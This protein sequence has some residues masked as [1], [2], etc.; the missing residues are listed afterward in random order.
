MSDITTIISATELATVYTV[1]NV[2]SIVAAV[3]LIVAYWKIFEKA[4]EPGWKSIVP[5]YNTY[6]MY[7]LLFSSG[8]M[9]L[10][11]FIPVVNIVMWVMRCKRTSHAFGHGA[12]YTLGLM[13]LPN[14]FAMI[15][16]FNS[17]EF[18]S[19]NAK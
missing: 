16:G 3:F 7:K 14:I 9:F 19:E 11:E 4:G 17:D 2:I 15:L 8:W 1:A 13:F 6:T 10:L 5:L 18:H 12:G